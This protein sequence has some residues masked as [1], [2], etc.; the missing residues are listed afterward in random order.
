MSIHDIIT[1][2]VRCVKCGGPVGCACWERC[3]CGITT[4]AGTP[5]RNMETR[6]CSTKVKYGKYNRRTRRYE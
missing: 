1:K 5:C 4:E 3:S 6:A 2:A